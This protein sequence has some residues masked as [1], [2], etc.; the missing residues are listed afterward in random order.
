MENKK[1]LVADD[2]INIVHVIAAKLRNNGFEVITADNVKDAYKLCCEQKPDAIVIDYELAEQLNA[3]TEL[4]GIPTIILTT[5]KIKPRL[6]FTER[7][8]KPFSPKELLA[9]V[10]NML[11]S[12]A[13][14]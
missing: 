7:L 12:L 11:T 4:S 13:A 8:N 1:I 10:E 5:K 9:S 3:K 6:N 2:E 14:K